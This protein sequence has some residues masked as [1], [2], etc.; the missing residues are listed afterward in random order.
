MIT[1][2]VSNPYWLGDTAEEKQADL[3]LHGHVLLMFDEDIISNEEW[4]VSAAALRFMRSVLYNHF[5]GEEQHMLPCCGH[6]MISSGD[7]QSVEIFGC[8]NGIDLMCCMKT[9]Q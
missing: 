5:L 7:N 8:R 1:L 9:G 6:F 2:S 4:C 3:C